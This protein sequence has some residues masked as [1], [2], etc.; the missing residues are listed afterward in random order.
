MK[1][2]FETTLCIVCLVLP[3]SAAGGGPALEELVPKVAHTR[4]TDGNAVRLHVFPREA[5]QARLELIQRAQ[6]H[7]FFSTFS[8]H[9][10][11]YG[12]QFAERLT[13]IVA[14]RQRSNPNFTVHCLIDSSSM[15]VFN[16][17]SRTFRD[18]RAAGA[19]VRGYN[20][21]SGS[22]AA[23]HDAR[24]HDK[25]L[26]V[27][28][29]W[30]LVSGRNIAR[31]Y[32]DP[33]GWWFDLD[34]E[35]EGQVVGDYQMHFLKAWAASIDLG[36][37]IRV[38]SRPESIQRRI[39][40]LWETGRFPGGLSPLDHYLTPDFFPIHESSPMGVRAAALYDNSLVWSRAATTD[41]VVELVQGAEREIDLMTPFP[42]LVDELTAVL[43]EAVERGVEVRLFV[44]G[45][46]AA[47]RRG[48]FW[49]SGLPTLIRLIGA[50]AEVWAWSGYG[51]VRRQLNEVGCSPPLLPPL[52][53]HGKMLRIDDR[54]ALIHSSNFNIRSTFYN[55]EAGLAVADRAFVGDLESMLDRLVELRDLEL[56]CDGQ[57][58]QIAVE[59]VVRRLTTEDLPRLRKTLGIKQGFLDSMAVIW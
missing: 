57:A 20:P 29:R 36:R 58:A 45:E 34:V 7:I 8:W 31:E 37:A 19:V 1:G 27:D 43:E 10:D 12:R 15:G 4:W 47:I 54:I 56:S 52:A 41:L 42:N 28:G 22:A 21:I 40:S 32:F 18:L 35:I 3:A 51:K 44:N 9:D 11:V 16:R 33:H 26:I 30:A 59:H 24:L 48:P 55:T 6:H 2:V 53:L 39:R 13:E 49:L 25:M 46:D 38:F 17:F 50:G 23:M 5:W 14:E